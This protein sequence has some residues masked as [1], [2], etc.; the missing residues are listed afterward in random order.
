MNFMNRTVLGNM[1]VQRLEQFRGKDAVIVCLQEDALMTCVTIAS[2]LRAWVYPLL[3]VPLYSNKHELLGAFDQD[4]VFCPLPGIEMPDNLAEILQ[5]QRPL[6]MKSIHDQMTEYGMSLDKHQM[7]GHDVI[8]AADI[9]TDLLP[10]TVAQHLLKEVSPRTVSA[11][12]G[13]ATTEAAQLLR[14]STHAE[15]LDVLSGIIFNNDH[16][17]EHADTYT[18]KQKRA[19]AQRIN[20]YWQ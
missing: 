16:Y 9:L 15:I 10:L 14:I 1:L 19:I 13:N 3:S 20:A 6:A 18:P 17:F 12:V 4:G 8:L 7:D 2:Q 5:K 11:V